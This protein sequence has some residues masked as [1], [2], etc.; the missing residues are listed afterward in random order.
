MDIKD[1]KSALQFLFSIENIQTRQ[2][3][4]EWCGDMGKKK[5]YLYV[6]RLAPEHWE[7]I[8]TPRNSVRACYQKMLT[9]YKIYN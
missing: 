5:L 6:Q 1:F 9:G 7:R 4:D 8:A 3:L 2:D